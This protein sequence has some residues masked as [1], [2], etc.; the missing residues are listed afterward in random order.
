MTPFETCKAIR[1]S[2]L[3]TTAEVMAYQTWSDE[4][5]LKQ[6]RE[7]SDSIKRA[8]W[9]DAIN[10]N[11]L[12]LEE[13]RELGF[14]RWSEDDP[15]MLIPLWLFPFLVP[16]FDGGCISGEKGPLVHSQMDNDN[17]GGVLAY[18]VYKDA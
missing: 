7:L 2:V 11:D 9:Y 13:M 18:G 17:R 3:R 6:I 10:P 14:A 5:A 16:V 12:T 15:L 1:L 8:S 4:F